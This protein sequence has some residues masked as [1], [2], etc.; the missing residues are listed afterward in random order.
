MKEYDNV[1]LRNGIVLTNIYILEEEDQKKW[2]RRG[3]VSEKGSKISFV[4]G[5]KPL[6]Q[7]FA[8][9]RLYPFAKQSFVYPFA[10]KSTI[11]K[12]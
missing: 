4:C 7:I 8:N 3:N 1:T 9:R 11:S 5:N 10:K 2:S 6:V 12:H